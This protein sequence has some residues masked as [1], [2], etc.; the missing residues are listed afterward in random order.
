MSGAN[1]GHEANLS[2]NLGGCGAAVRY[3]GDTL[4]GND[5]EYSGGSAKLTGY[6]SVRH[7]LEG[8]FKVGNGELGIS[9]GQ[10]RSKNVGTPALGM[11]MIKDDADSIRLG[12]TGKFDFGSVEARVYQHSIDHVMDNYTL[13]TYTAAASRMKAPATSDDAGFAFALML[14]KGSNTF[15]LGVDGHNNDF[16]VYQQNI[17]ANTFRDLFVNSSR[18][19]LGIYGEWEARPD[20]AWRTVL[21]IRTET[22]Q[23]SSGALARRMGS[24]GAPN[25]AT[26]FATFNAA[27]RDKTDHNWDVT[28]SGR[29]TANS[30]LALEFGFARKTRSPS[31]VERYL[32]VPSATYGSADGQLDVGDI[33]LKPE[34][35]NQVSLTA[36]WQAGAMYI[37]PTVFYNRVNDYIQGL[38]DGTTFAPGTTPVLKF[39]N[40]NAQLHGIDGAFGYQAS[41]A[42]KFDG[43]LSY[44]RGKNRDNGDHLYRIA[45]LRLTLA[46]DYT[47]GPWNAVA[48]IKA[49]A[50]QT[51]VSAYNAET[52][53]GGWGIMNLRGAYRFAKQGKLNFGIENLFDKYYEDHLSGKNQVNSAALGGGLAINQR[54]PNAGRFAYLSAEY[55]W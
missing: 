34:V 23:M 12:Y 1:G 41:S 40:I 50:R 15:R 38:R 29:Y 36:D 14:P 27:N 28:A 4:Q 42:W 7:Q 51:R 18:D 20:Q 47:T 10:H 43:V 22:V 8:G 16:N 3:S 13:R 37:K 9:F 33:N 52:P 35:S 11:D 39:S 30:N 46:A 17:T 24:G 2:L 19:R 25:E 49:A 5:L 53:T 21:G 31:I 6:D 54:V 48:E 44:V 32:G 26:R 55:A 45:P